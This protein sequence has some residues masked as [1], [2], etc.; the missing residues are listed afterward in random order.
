MNHTVLRVAAATLAVA[1]TLAGLGA[2]AR[3]AATDLAAAGTVVV[4]P[5]VE[6]TGTPERATAA[7][8]AAGEPARD[9]AGRS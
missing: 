4:L 6:V 8:R 3:L 9:A 7:R 5:R 1:V 2:I